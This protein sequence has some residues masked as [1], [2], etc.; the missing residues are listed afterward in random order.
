MR[1][2]SL[3]SPE[4]KQ[5]VD[6]RD[7]EDVIVE[8]VMEAMKDVEGVSVM[9]YAQYYEV[10][11]S[12]SRGDSVRI[13]RAICKSSLAKCCIQIPKLFS[14]QEVSTEDKEEKNDRKA[15][16]RMGRHM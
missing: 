10:S 3:A 5:N 2:Y 14:G 16:N 11:P 7:Y 4:H 15:K 8:A 6:L 9:V 1:R 12:P 13:G